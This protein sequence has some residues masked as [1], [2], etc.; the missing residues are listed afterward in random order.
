MPINYFEKEVTKSQERFKQTYGVMTVCNLNLRQ[1]VILSIINLNLLCRIIQSA[2]KKDQ[3]RVEIREF[4]RIR[5]TL[6]N[7]FKIIERNI[8]Y[9]TKNGYSGQADDGAGLGRSLSH[10]L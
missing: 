8:D 10:H 1:A 5:N 6:N 9:G 2:A 7:H 4:I 3:V